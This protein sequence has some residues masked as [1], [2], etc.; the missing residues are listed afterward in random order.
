MANNHR[1]TRIDKTLKDKVLKEVAERNKPKT[2]IAKENGIAVSTIAYWEGRKKKAKKPVAKKGAFKGNAGNAQ[3]NLEASFE[4]LSGV[5]R[6]IGAL[7]TAE[8]EFLAL[9]LKAHPLE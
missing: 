9:W 7:D 3:S 2:Q 5:V 1:T 6:L 4:K 8:R